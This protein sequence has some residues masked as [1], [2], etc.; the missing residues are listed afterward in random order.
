MDINKIFYALL[1][2]GVVLCLLGRLD[3]G[4]IALCFTVY[5]C[6]LYLSE[7]IVSVHRE[8]EPEEPPRKIGY[9]VQDEEGNDI[10]K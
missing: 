3:F 9:E 8:E 10:E 2:A 1:G 5:Y 4:W 7:V 6:T